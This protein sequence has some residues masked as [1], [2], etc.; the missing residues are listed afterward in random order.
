MADLG[1]WLQ[2][3]YKVP[4]PPRENAELDDDDRDDDQQA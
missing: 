4:G 1:R 2:G 3:D